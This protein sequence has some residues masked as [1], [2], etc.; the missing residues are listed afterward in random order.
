MNIKEIVCIIFCCYLCSMDLL[1]AQENPADLQ[2]DKIVLPQGGQFNEVRQIYQ[3]REG[4]IWMAT[5]SGLIR[6]D[7]YDF[8]TFKSNLY[9]RNLLTNNTI[10]ALAEDSTGNLWIG[11][12]KGLNVLHKPTG[13]VRKI[14]SEKLKCDFIQS[15]LV[16]PGGDIWM[17]TNRGIQVYRPSRDTA[18]L[19]SHENTKNQ[20]GGGDIKSLLRDSRGQV[21][22]GTWANGLWRY[23]PREDTFYAYPEINRG[24]S[25]HV[26]FEDSGGNI[27]VGTWGYGLYRLENPYQPATTR[28][29][30]YRHVPDKRNSLLDDIIYTL[31]EDLS[32]HTLWVGSRKGLSLLKDKA[33]PYSFVNYIPGKGEH[34]LSYNELNTICRDND[35]MMWLGL[36]GGGV[37]RVDPRKQQFNLH[38]L[39][40]MKDKFSVNSVRSLL[41]D[42]DGKIWLG[43]GSFGMVMHDRQAERMYH[44]S[45]LPDFRAFPD[46]PTVNTI[47]RRRDSREIWFGTYDGGIYIY[48]GKLPAGKRVRLMNMDNTPWLVNACIYHLLEDSKG[49]IWIATRGGINMVAAGGEAYSFTEI[50]TPERMYDRPAIM[51]IGED[52]SGYLWFGTN[53]YGAF[54]ATVDSLHP[55]Q[56]RF[57]NYSTFNGKLFTDNV[58]CFYC[59]RQRRFW[60]GTEGEGLAVYDS[61]QDCIPTMHRE[62]SLPG[63]AVFSM[64]EDSRGDLWLGTDE[65]LI[66]LTAGATVESSSF[67]LYTTIDGL[68]DNSFTRNAV[69]K[70]K[71]GELFFGGHKGYNSFYP[72]LLRENKHVPPVVITDIKIYNQSWIRLEDKKRSKISALAPGFTRKIVLS[73]DDNNFN[74]NF[75]VLSYANPGQNKYAYRLE[76]FDTKWKFTDA[77]RRFAYYNNLKSG[78]YRFF[79]KGANEH[80]VWSTSPEVLEIVVKPAPWVTWWAWCLYLL[81]VGAVV[82]YIFKLMHKRLEME[83]AVKLVE[84]KRQKSEEMNHA[85]LQFFTNIT[86]ELMTPLTIISAS[87]DEL[88]LVLPAHTDYYEVL[89]SNTRRLMRLIQQI[90]EFRK[91]ESG[92]LKLKVSADSL[93]RFVKNSID[94]FRP[95]IKKKGITFSLVMEAEEITG[96]F[97]PDKLDKILYNLLSNAAKYN[98]ENGMVEIRLSYDDRQD[99]AVI[100][101]KDNGEGISSEAM[102]N[103]FQRFYEGNY[104]RFNTV[105]TGIGL[106]LTKDLVEL[107]RGTISVESEKG[108]GAM[109]TVSFPLLRSAYDE[110]QIDDEN[111]VL[112]LSAEAEGG[113]PAEQPGAGE[114]PEAQRVAGSGGLPYK[115]LLVEDNEELLGLMMRLLSHDYQVVAARNGREGIEAAENQG[116]DLIVS[117]VMMPEMD[118]IEFCR[119]IKGK[120]E[121]CHIPVILLTAKQSEEDK[122]AGYDSG[123]DSYLTKPF[124][125]SLLHSRIKGLLKNRERT[126]RDFKKQMVLETKELNYT[127]LDEAFMQKAVDCIYQQLDNSEF[128]VEQFTQA[129]GT[130][131]SALYAKLK[132]LT[133]L[134]TSAFIRNIRLKA[135]CQLIEEKKKIR[136]SELAYAVGFNDAKYFSACFKKEFG[137]LPTEYMEKYNSHAG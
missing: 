75:A 93:S 62:Y 9:D 90:L 79:L 98:K 3:D 84:M 88:K 81:A 46:M 4:Y 24:H 118:G 104:R 35:N 21:W 87:L 41:Q 131:K 42:D 107:H 10:Q 5:N 30:S 95:L 50:Y 23:D 74:I 57:E 132:S 99:R 18:F 61:V 111:P 44:Y 130:S 110:A 136:I 71:D 101:V 103:L 134:H 68:Q 48:D 31:S 53:Q 72:E 67:N 97:D 45:E 59:D 127:S 83:A 43:V 108:N 37:N 137:M 55:D 133:G 128:D 56:T 114:L 47:L 123:A 6:Y 2:F 12:A 64:A 54:R 32:S 1:F 65:G 125:L 94:S 14:G 33:D 116:V 17:G 49:N 73:H 20:F 52:A 66:R 86:H 105:G 19:L 120:L 117:D 126:A 8:L 25:A 112:Q 70:S 34:S 102:K 91:A 28:Y 124:S 60:V 29:V 113:E 85:K 119:Y 82:W 22:I 36:F 106:S 96:Y 16:M 129:M 51:T 40:D 13:E 115:I 69:Y 89:S 92:N 135:A 100:S 7:G 26:I 27:W 11:T 38:R 109:F 77:S 15:L 76:G 39:E 122:I 63:D 58:A 80:G 121:L 78:E